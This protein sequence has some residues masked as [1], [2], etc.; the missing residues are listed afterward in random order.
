[1]FDLFI[2]NNMLLI[3]LI[4]LKKKKLENHLENSKK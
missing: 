1:M 2:N 4:T 3:L